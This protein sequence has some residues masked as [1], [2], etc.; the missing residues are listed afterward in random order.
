MNAIQEAEDHGEKTVNNITVEAMEK[1]IVFCTH[2][3]DHE[4]PI[5]DK[6]M[7]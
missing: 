2:L 7:P 5:I 1:V 3:L 6:T 4:P